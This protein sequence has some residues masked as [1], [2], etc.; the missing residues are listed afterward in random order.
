MKNLAIHLIKKYQIKIS[1]KL[2]ER[3]MRCL[4]N[5]SCSNYALICLEKY[6]V[7][8]AII[9]ITSRLLSCNPI[10]AYLKER[11]LKTNI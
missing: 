10:N 8:I 1:P 3:G 6:N 9:L 2:Q 5:P 4:F 7:I 11:K